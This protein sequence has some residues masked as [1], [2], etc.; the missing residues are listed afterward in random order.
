MTDA[1][2]YEPGHSLDDV[3]AMLEA[4]AHLNMRALGYAM[5]TA[6]AAAG[7][8]KALRVVLNHFIVN[9]MAV[10]LGAIVDENTGDVVPWTSEYEALM[11]DAHR[12][13]VGCCLSII[14]R[15]PSQ[16]WDVE[17]TM[18]LPDVETRVLRWFNITREAQ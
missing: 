15:W 3:R 13:A 7:N 14:K 16:P 4:G 18:S 12:G 11:V 2:H 10:H 9:W 17:P 8:D 5:D 1:P 6:V